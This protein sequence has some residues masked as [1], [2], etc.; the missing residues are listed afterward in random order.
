M[1]KRTWTINQLS[2][3]L[4]ECNTLAEVVKKL[5]L[6][7]NSQTQRR[8]RN[9]I[10]DNN[11]E[12]LFE[13]DKSRIG[14]R[15]QRTW[16]DAQLIEA[17]RHSSTLK[18]VIEKLGLRN[19]QGTQNTIKK[20][21]SKLQLSTKHFKRTRRRETKTFEER[22]TVNSIIDSGYLRDKLTE[23]GLLEERCGV[24]GLEPLWQNSFLRLQLDHING[25]R[26]DNRL[27]NLRLLCPN[28]HSQTP[29][30]GGRKRRGKGR[31]L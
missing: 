25:D 9:T 22:L 11:L 28:C 19:T 31:K 7:W 16:T 18:E 10:L 17:V 26:H 24:C 1:P 12:I 13:I 15:D 23:R 5:G 2:K 29:T 3:I 4:P 20:W 27:E 8:I 21:I 14:K 30:Y 6:K